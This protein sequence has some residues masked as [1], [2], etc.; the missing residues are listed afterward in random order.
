MQNKAHFNKK[1]KKAI[2]FAKSRLSREEFEHALR[3][4]EIVEEKELDDES[5]IAALLHDLVFFKKCDINII[6]ETF[7]E[8]VAGL[9]KEITLTE[10]VLVKNYSKVPNQTLGS[11]ILSVSSDLRTI[12]IQFAELIDLLKNNKGNKMDILKLA[13]ISE[14]IYYPLSVK[15]GLGDFSWKIQDYSFK[16]REPKNY[17]KVK[18]LINKSIEERQEKIEKLKLELTKL[19]PYK[20]IQIYGRPKN[21]RS[22]FNKLKKVPIKKMYDIYGLRIICDRQRECYEILGKIHSKYNFIEEAFD[23]YIAK[24]GKGVGKEGYQSLHTAIIWEKDIFEI[25][26]RTWQMHMRTESNIYW[27]YKRLGKDKNFENQLSWARQLI[28]WQKSIGQKNNKRKIVNRQI[29]AFTPK[30][31]VVAL[32]NGATVLDFA[33]LIH[34][35]VGKKAKGAII[36]GKLMPLDTKV[37]NLDTIEIITDNKYTIKQSWLVIAQI[38]KA[39]Q[40][41]RSHFNIKSVKKKINEV[42]QKNIKKIKLAECCHPLPGEDVV[43]VKTTKRKIIIHKTD[44]PNI[45]NIP[46]NKLIEIGFERNKGKTKIKVQAIDRIGLLGEIL[47]TFKKNDVNLV[48]TNFG[49]KKSGFVE[50]IFEVEVSNVKKIDKVIDKIES[51]ASVQSVLRE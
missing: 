46:K 22:I 12:I 44:C 26:I 32:K 30:R 25:Q 3:T 4:A 21:F 2:K 7:G 37:S 18:K 8:E 29:F 20:N 14:E 13:N 40:K 19:L 5:I 27:E 39:K 51:I 42:G 15:L 48:N 34:T 10:E 45:K 49:I 9:V 24:E 1:Y 11:L 6:E 38:E 47:T 17:S 43:G 35:E 23:D 33:F 36:N 16:I 31:D 50:A 28:E 41:I